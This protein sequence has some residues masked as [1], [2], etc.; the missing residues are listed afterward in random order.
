MSSVIAPAKSC[1]TPIPRELEIRQAFS[2]R[3]SVVYTTPNELPILNLDKQGESHWIHPKA[4]GNYPAIANSH[5]NKEKLEDALNSPLK[6]YTKSFSESTILEKNE[7][8]IANIAKSISNTE[9][10][11]KRGSLFPHEVFRF[12]CRRRQGIT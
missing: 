9:R 7:S 3:I 11:N 6:S 2:Q 5:K 4:D 8:G 12:Y 10:T 1:N